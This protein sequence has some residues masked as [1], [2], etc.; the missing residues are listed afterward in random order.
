MRCSDRTD[1]A[2]M[3][4]MVATFPRRWQR[5]LSAAQLTEIDAALT[6]ATTR[7]YDRERSR[8]PRLP[9]LAPLSDD[10]EV[11]RGNIAAGARRGG[12]GQTAAAPL[13]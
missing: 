2:T 3:S 9:S 10:Q 12:I 8:R 7:G 11:L 5:R 4:R 13:R 1:A 6:V